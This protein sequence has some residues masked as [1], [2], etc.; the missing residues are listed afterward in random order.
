MLDLL[1]KI[2][3]GYLVIFII[4][5]L[6]IAWNLFTSRSTV[7]KGTDNTEGGDNEKGIH[8]Y[9]N[10][11][12]AGAIRGLAGGLLLGDLGLVSGINS[13][14]VYGVLNPVMLYLGH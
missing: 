2:H 14:V 1:D 8:K 4:I 11:A 10:A 9:I 5:I 6:S 3:I 7:V 12:H 13:A